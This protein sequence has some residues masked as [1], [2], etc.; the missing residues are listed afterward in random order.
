MQ[1][2]IGVDP[3]PVAVVEDA[4]IVTVCPS[5]A[6]RARA[7]AQPLI[8]G[9]KVTSVVLFGADGSESWTVMARRS[10]HVLATSTG[11]S[12]EEALFDVLAKLGVLT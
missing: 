9:V 4:T 3:P 10:A 6:A 1:H 2:R 8:R 12:E 5:C 7:F 11:G